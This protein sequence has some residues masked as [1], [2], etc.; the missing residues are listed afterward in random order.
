M[1]TTKK[2]K[3]PTSV[4]TNNPLTWREA[5]R[6]RSETIKSSGNK[7][8]GEYLRKEQ[9]HRRL[10]TGA[11]LGLVLILLFSIYYNIS[12]PN[13]DVQQNEKIAVLEQQ[14]ATISKPGF[15]VDAAI[16][17]AHPVAS[18]CLN[19]TD[20]ADPASIDV[21]TARCGWNGAGVANVAELYND[22]DPALRAGVSTDTVSAIPYRVRFSNG[23]IALYY[24]P[25]RKTGPK[26]VVVAGNGGFYATVPTFIAHDNQVD[27]D[28]TSQQHNPFAEAITQ[29]VSGASRYTVPGVNISFNANGLTAAG[30]KNVTVYLGSD[31]ARVV[32]AQVILSG[33]TTGAQFVQQVAFSMVTGSNGNWLVQSFGPDTNPPPGQ[34]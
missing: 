12:A 15:P 29:L 4:Q 6:L 11:I 18:Q 20:Q 24:V 14:V 19:Y 3:V 33:P 27:T 13:H 17:A 10:M 8:L 31:T 9:A 7:F 23:N 25:V 28:V 30:V 21:L 26:S 22:S 1:S 34:S 2:G 5:F 32:T 16:S